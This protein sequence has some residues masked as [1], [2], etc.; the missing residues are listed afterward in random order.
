VKRLLL[1]CLLLLLAG[2]GKETTVPAREIVVQ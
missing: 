1:L 2:C